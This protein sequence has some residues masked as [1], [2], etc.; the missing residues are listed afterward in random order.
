MRN[1]HFTLGAHRSI[2]TTTNINSFKDTKAARA[3]NDSKN[4]NERKARMR[5][6][7]FSIGADARS[8]NYVTQN[9]ST[10]KDYS[11]SVGAQKRSDSASNNIRS[12]HFQFGVENSP[13]V[14]V[15]KADFSPK[16][17]A[18]PPKLRTDLMRTNFEFGRNI[19]NSLTTAQLDFKDHRGFKRESINQQ[20]RQGLM[21]THF[22]LGK[23]PYSYAGRN[24]N[25][26]YGSGHKNATKNEYNKFLKQSNFNVGEPDK[27]NKF[28]KTQYNADHKERDIKEAL[29]CE[30]G[31]NAF[32]SS[33]QMNGR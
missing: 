8:T 28:F 33:I 1:S 32:L 6:H 30:F 23:H 21:Q 9:A 19:P 22:V 15:Q 26:E 7:N 20:Q 4:E 31:P 29:S 3:S 16:G 17:G 25:A 14:S 13:M 27:A 10:H 12:S 11:R 5:G 24:F 2:F 18:K